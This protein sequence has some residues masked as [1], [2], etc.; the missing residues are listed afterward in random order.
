MSATEGLRT[1][2]Q[3]S[4][5]GVDGTREQ[6][7]KS[8]QFDFNKDKGRPRRR[9]RKHGDD[10]GGGDEESGRRRHRREKRER[11]EGESEGATG[12]RR[13]EGREDERSSNR[14]SR[15]KSPASDASGGTVELPPRF[16][17]QGR[18]IPERGDDRIADNLEDFLNGKGTA[19]RLFQRFKGDLLGG[20]SG[21]RR[22]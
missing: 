19:G 3:R 9:R 7:A 18:K 14:H 2:R 20:G 21:S 13:G 6:G 10:D 16:N 5:G 22:G 11:R 12:E 4:P 8:V 17:E 1:P 15:S